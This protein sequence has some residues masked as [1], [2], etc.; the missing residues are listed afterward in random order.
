MS[1]NV[2]GRAFRVITFGESHG[3][4]VGLVIDGVQPGLPVDTHLIQKALDRRRPGQSE[5][6]TARQEAD[7]VDIISG[8]WEGKT[9]GAPLCMLIRNRDQNPRDY[10]ELKDILRPGHAGF[11]FLQK[12]GLYDYRG[13][14]RASGRET[15]SRVAAGALALQFLK[16]RG[17]EIIAYTRQIA[18]VEIE[19]VDLSQVEKNPVRA[20]DERAAEKMEQAIRQARREGDS[21]GGVVEI[22]VKNCPSGIG[23]PV[24][25]KLDAELAGALMSIG[26][27]KAFEM[28]SGFR[29]ACMKGSQHNDPFYF[30]DSTQ[31]IRT[32]THHAGGVLGGISN[33][34]D[35]LMRI[36][37]KP[38]SSIARVQETVDT[39]GTPRRY[40]TGGRH[41]PCIC[42]RMVPVAQAMA[43][44]TLLDLISLQERISPHPSTETV[45]SKID[46]VDAEMLLLLIRRRQ[47]VREKSRQEKAKTSFRKQTTGRENKDQ[48]WKETATEADL[49]QKVAETF[50][51]VLRTYSRPDKEVNKTNPDSKN[52]GSK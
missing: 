7:K 46:A 39:R 31:K 41:D 25:E 18:D 12:Y 51:R 19:K 8:V 13:G 35:L 2:F 17:I 52:T 23:E 30:D 34:E 4:Y 37:V 9:T 45:Q 15:A 27:V 24:F 16:Q 38:P 10:R 22:V 50:L 3:P 43:A 36:T 20:P 49:P 40:K 26:A 21:L 11:T 14:G 32:R 29:A 28:G 33:G 5:M 42:P 1:G 6:V 48:W 47:L 44:L